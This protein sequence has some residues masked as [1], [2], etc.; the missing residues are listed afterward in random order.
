MRAKKKKTISL[1]DIIMHFIAIALFVVV[2]YPLILVLSYSF[3][4]P[5]MVATGEVLFFPKGL[6]IEGYKQV[7]FNKNLMTGYTNTIFYT[8]TGTMVNLFV[9]VP[10]GYVLTKSYRGLTACVGIKGRHT[11]QT[12]NTVLALQEA[13]GIFAFHHDGSG[14]QTSFITFLEIGRAHV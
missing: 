9:T 2:A 12:V 6:T 11:N 5:G 13:V 4:D 8:I 14:L 3:S 7:F 10:A 1:F